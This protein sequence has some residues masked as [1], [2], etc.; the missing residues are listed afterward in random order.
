MNPEAKGPVPTTPSGSQWR[1][2]DLALQKRQ[3]PYPCPTHT[4]TCI[5]LRSS[6][7]SLLGVQDRLGITFQLLHVAQKLLQE[8]LTGRHTLQSEV[9]SQ[10]LQDGTVVAQ[11]GGM[12][13]LGR[14]PGK[15]WRGGA[16]SHVSRDRLGKGCLWP[17]CPVPSVHLGHCCR[18][19]G[20][21][22]PAWHRRCHRN[23]SH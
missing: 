11:G 18:P 1:Q 22:P 2:E 9:H 10:G 8:V 12:G 17:A 20:C 6:P 19:E 23:P 5:S 14:E 16:M 4:V 21:L 15:L 3:T 7:Y 13:Q